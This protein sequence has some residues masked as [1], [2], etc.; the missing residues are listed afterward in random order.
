MLIPIW[1]SALSVSRGVH[2]DDVTDDDIT[3]MLTIAVRWSLR[4]I[5]SARPGEHLNGYALCTDDDG[6]GAYPIG[7]TTEWC[8]SSAPYPAARYIPVEWAYSEGHAGFDAVNADLAR[9]SDAA[10]QQWRDGDG[11]DEPW[12]GG[13]AFE[14][15]VRSLE[16][17]RHDGWLPDDVLLIVTTTDPGPDMEQLAADSVRRLNTAQMNAAWRHAY[18]LSDN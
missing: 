11:H 13:L 17:L 9:R 6:Q 18:G 1:H 7:T 8:R 10:W 5:T 15:M 16:R 3:D 2:T 12:P 4:L 14:C